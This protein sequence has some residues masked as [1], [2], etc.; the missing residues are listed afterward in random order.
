MTYLL[1]EQ[2]DTI[3]SSRNDVL[4]IQHAVRLLQNVSTGTANTT[5]TVEEVDDEPEWKRTL[6][7]VLSNVFLFFLIF[8]LSATCDSRHLKKQLTNKFAIGTGITMQYVFMPVLGCI[9]VSIF[10]HFGLT[11][12]M[13][14]ALLVVTASPGGS[15]SNWWCSTF[16]ADLPL[17]VAMTTISSLLSV[18]LL[19]L[20]LFFYSW[21]AYGVFATNT[22]GTDASSIVKSLDFK[23]LFQSLAVVLSA[24]ISGLLAGYKFDTTT[25][26]TR[27]NKLGSICG[28]CLIIVSIVVVSGPKS[29]LGSLPWSFYV[30]TIIPCLG[31]LF[32]AHCFSKLAKL[33]PPEVMSIAIE[34]CCQNTGIATSVAITM[35][36]NPTERAQAVAV[37]LFYGIVSAVSILF[38]CIFNWKMGVSTNTDT[39][40]FLLLLHD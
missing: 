28:I 33:S 17:S 24:I 15:Y 11:Q 9:G 8:G 36:D 32:L 34:C 31:G 6:A 23:S 4:I 3:T 20:N 35:F 30:A 16:N 7:I 1:S 14:I 10:S 21:L 39:L 27:A 18:V 19:P 38:F 37:P 13:G 26:H 2:H 12:A 5:T 40:L 25:F 29:D 22:T